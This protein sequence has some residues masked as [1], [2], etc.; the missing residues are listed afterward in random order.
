MPGGLSLAGH[1]STPMPPSPACLKLLLPFSVSLGC[2]GVI[3]QGQVVPAVG[4]TSICD[5]QWGKP[6]FFRY[7]SGW[8]GG[9]ASNS[10]QP[11]SETEQVEMAWVFHLSTRCICAGPLTGL[12]LLGTFPA[13]SGPAVGG[14]LSC[15][16]DRRQEDTK[17]TVSGHT[18]DGCTRLRWGKV[19]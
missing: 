17:E 8:L 10:S 5:R 1:L 15:E 12:S 2:G 9:T 13:S 7:P 19:S 6:P 3:Y 4:V 11:P 14:R 18:Q 16:M